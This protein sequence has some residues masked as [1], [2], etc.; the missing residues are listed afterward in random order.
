M[1]QLPECINLNGCAGNEVPIPLAP[2]PFSI[3][4]P[5]IVDICGTM[6]LYSL[7]FVMVLSLASNAQDDCGVTLTSTPLTCPDDAD[8]TLSVT[9]GT[10]GPF[11]YEWSHDPLLLDATATDLPVGFYTVIVS[12][13]LGCDTVIDVAVDVP[14]VTPLGTITTTDITCPGTNDGTVTFTV[15]PGPYTWEW[16]FD[17]A[18]TSTVL[19]DLGP[20]DYTVLVSGGLCPS[21]ISG[22][23][24]DPAITIGGEVVYCPSEPPVLTVLPEWGF[25]PDVFVWNTGQTAGSFTVVVGTEGTVEVTATDTSSGCVLMAD[26]F[27][28]LLEPPTVALAVPDSV[29]IRVPALANTSISNADSLVWRWGASGFSNLHDPTV[30]FDEPFWQPIS[31]QGFDATGCGTAPVE[32]SIYVR[33]RIPATFT[34][35]QVPCTSLV[36]LNLTSASDSCA[37]FIGDSLVM[38][39][40]SGLFQ[41]DFRRY[42]PYDLT[43]YSTQR[44]HCDDTLSVTIDV[45]LEPT[46]H[47]PNA[48]TPNG[49]GI[50][51][52]WP[53]DVEIPDAG[54]Q[55][56]LFDRWGANLWATTDT[57]EKWDGSEQPMGV[58][59]YTMRMRD[60]CEAAKEIT[61]RGFVTLFR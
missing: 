58:Y 56:Q 8:A 6:R 10:G 17:P 32:D 34:A 7:L 16:T 1:H 14:P 44:N 38:H 60:P 42:L 40:C 3:Y 54:Y 57:Q 41:R 24:G 52:Q 50:N 49:D 28:T 23:L 29:C 21:Y 27:L 47:L 53:G 37:F 22:Y 19:T 13:A 35:T 2:V 12:G 61:K 33:P 46:L 25:Q 31:L 26:V 18:E 36:E 30:F 59:I 43:F 11:T 15:A 55:V 45:E 9:G 48:F 39:D 5:A 20:G 51:D 4:F